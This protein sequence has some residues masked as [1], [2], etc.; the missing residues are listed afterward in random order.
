ME[1]LTSSIGIFDSGIGGLTVVKQLIKELPNE[2]L[3][4]LGDTARVPYGSKSPKTVTQFSLQ[5]SQFLVSQNVKIIVVACNT[6]SAEAIPTLRQNFDVRVFGVI[7]PGS[8]QAAKITKN[9]KIGVIGTTGTIKSNTYQK[10]I[11][12]LDSKIDVF[13]QACPLFVPLAEEGWFDKEAT[14]L[15]A[16]EYLTN[17]V[18]LGIDTLILGCTH[19]PLLSETI[20]KVVGDSVT[21]IDSGKETAKFVAEILKNLN[22]L[23]EKQT[24]GE[25][26]Y[27]LTDLPLKFQEVGSRFLGSQIREVTKVS[28]DGLEAWEKW[29]ILV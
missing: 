13:S 20:Q 6:A 27:F 2:N 4:Y 18:E 8:K 22:Q 11:Q 29:E 10:E 14:F 15:I 3:I 17:L 21:L 12:K 28:I 24:E 1:N 7:E 26:K 23:S 9:G 5:N 25:R 19:Y 16:K